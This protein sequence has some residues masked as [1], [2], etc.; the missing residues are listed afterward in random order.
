MCR[1]RYH[2]DI[3]A[4]NVLQS[5]NANALELMRATECRMLELQNASHQRRLQLSA[6]QETLAEMQLENNDLSDSLKITRENLRVFCSHVEKPLP[7]MMT[8]REDTSAIAA[9]I[10][11]PDQVLTEVMEEV[12]TTTATTITS[13]QLST[14]P[15]EEA[16]AD[17]LS[18]EVSV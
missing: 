16:T 4:N 13:Y 5:L 8:E 9:A 17:R 15:R 7:S 1:V 6:L 2:V 11:T 14:E 10:T 3:L 18:I 12:D